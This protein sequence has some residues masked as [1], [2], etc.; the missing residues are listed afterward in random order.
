MSFTFS[1]EVITQIT[2]LARLS[3][4][5]TRDKNNIQEDLNKIVRMVSQISEV[6]TQGIKPMA[7]PFDNMFQSLR[8]DIVT[9]SNQRDKLQEISPTKTEAGLYLVPAVIE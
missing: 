9:E 8:P 2:H 7:H 4:E 3:G 6:N 5:N 1:P